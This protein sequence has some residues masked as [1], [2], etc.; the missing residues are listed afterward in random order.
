MRRSSTN[1]GE[2]LQQLVSRL[3]IFQ[4]CRL[5]KSF[6]HQEPQW[7][8]VVLPKDTSQPSCQ[9]PVFLSGSSRTLRRT[10]APIS[11]P[12]W[13]R[14]QPKCSFAVLSSHSG[15]SKADVAQSDSRK[16]PKWQM[17]ALVAILVH[18]CLLAEDDIRNL[19]D[20]TAGRQALCRSQPPL[21]HQGREPKCETRNASKSRVYCA[22]SSTFR[23]RRHSDCPVRRGICSRLSVK[24]K[25]SAA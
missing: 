2:G 12:L 5:K 3:T 11:I 10:V 23:C 24:R 17:A 22:H 16:A 1:L 7:R 9:L 4:D 19:P 20:A 18:Q 25:L 6:A 13:I 8:C 14:R 15:Q 21:G